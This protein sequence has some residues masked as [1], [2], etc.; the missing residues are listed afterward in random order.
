MM[1]LAAIASDDDDAF[2]VRLPVDEFL[3]TSRALFTGEA[4]KEFGS[5]CIQRNSL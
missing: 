3:H 2:L 4:K 5:D 1:I